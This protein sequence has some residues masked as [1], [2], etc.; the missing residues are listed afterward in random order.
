M[1]ILILI[2]SATLFGIGIDG[3][4]VNEFSSKDSCE[5]A[6]SLAKEQWATKD[7]KSRCVSV[8]EYKKMLS[9]KAQLDELKKQIKALQEKD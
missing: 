6:L 7:E 3:V 9:T 5:V 4:K 1:Y 8:D 2:T